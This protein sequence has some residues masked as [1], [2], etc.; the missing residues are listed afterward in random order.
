MRVKH[1]E[2]LTWPPDWM[3]DVIL[4]PGVQPVITMEELLDWT[5]DEY[6]VMVYK[7]S[8]RFLG[9]YSS[10]EEAEAA[11]EYRYVRALL[12]GGKLPWE[13]GED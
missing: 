13:A 3:P 2:K 6:A 5:I 10:R 11:D 8:G 12:P 4:P 1:P 9:E 7:R